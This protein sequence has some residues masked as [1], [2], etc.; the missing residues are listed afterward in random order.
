MKRTSIPAF[1]ALALMLFSIVI[2]IRGCRQTHQA[3]AT[4]SSYA[5][6]G[7]VWG[8]LLVH[9][10]VGL[11]AGPGE[12]LAVHPAGTPEEGIDTGWLEPL[13]KGMEKSISDHPGFTLRYHAVRPEGN[14]LFHPLPYTH[15]SSPDIRLALRAGQ[16][17][18]AIISFA[19]QIPSSE[20]P[21]A[22]PVILYYPFPDQGTEWVENRW[23]DAAVVPQLIIPSEPLRND[24]RDLY[25]QIILP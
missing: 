10:A 18:V 25:F 23:V 11:A 3:S 20:R 21:E 17:P 15:A 7:R 5:P 9:Q 6:I 16:K 19:G 2:L 24:N 8:E 13:I 1:T 14:D 22:V 4:T 12:I